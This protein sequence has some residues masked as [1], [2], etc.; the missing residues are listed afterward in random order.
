M[1][2]LPSLF[3]FVLVT[4]GTVSGRVGDVGR[5]LE[6]SQIHHRKLYRATEGAAIEGRFIVVLSDRVENVLQMALNL[7]TGSDAQLE[8]EYDSVVKGFTV[9]KLIADF[10]VAILDEDLVEYVEEVSKLFPHCKNAKI[11]IETNTDRW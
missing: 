5:D 10:L 3:L 9:S 4:V 1:F 8:Y 6:L 11:S 7:L 2:I